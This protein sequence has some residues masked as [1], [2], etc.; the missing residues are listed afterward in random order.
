MVQKPHFYCPK[1]KK[2]AEEILEIYFNYEERRV[3][4]GAEYEM[5]DVIAVDSDKTVC[6]DCKTEVVEL[7][8]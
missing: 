7:E 8:E 1:C 2:P 6:L 5:Q 4:N 3:W